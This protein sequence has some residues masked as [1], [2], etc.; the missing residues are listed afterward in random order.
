[1]GVDSGRVPVDGTWLRHVH[2][3]VDALG[4]GRSRHGGRFNPPSVPAL[5]LADS[6]PT[7]WAEWYRWLA[8]EGRSPADFVPRDLYRVSVDLLEVVDLSSMTARRQAGLPTRLRPSRAQWPAFQAVGERIASSGA[9]GILYSSA[10]RGR[11]KCLC[12]F[13]AGL[14]RLQLDGPPRRVVDPPA[15]PRGLRT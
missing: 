9:Q 15:P 11:A 14:A 6:E 5:Y 4:V 3:S 12:V 10:V 13:E 8:E 7:A 2:P 1:M